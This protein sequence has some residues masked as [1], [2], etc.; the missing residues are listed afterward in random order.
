VNRSFWFL[1]TAA[2]ACSA[3]V[4][5]WCPGSALA[6]STTPEQV[7]ARLS[8]DDV[9]RAFGLSGVARE[10]TLPRL[11]VIRVGPHWYELAPELRLNA[12]AEWMELW[13]TSVASGVVAIVDAASE[14]SVVGFDAAG[15]PHLQNPSQEPAQEPAHGPAQGSTRGS[16]QS[17]DASHDEP[18]PLIMA[19]LEGDVA[20]ARA[21]IEDGA[22]PDVLAIVR[23]RDLLGPDPQ[24]D[25]ISRVEA[26]PL[27][28]AAAADA[29]ELVTLLVE[30]DAD[31][32]RTTEQGL[33]PLM[34]A[35]LD[36][37]HTAAAAL[38]DGGADPDALEPVWAEL[39]LAFGLAEPIGAEPG[40]EV[41]VTAL[42]AA[43]ALGREGL[44][45][46][47]LDHH[48]DPNLTV[49]GSLTPL[50]LA[51]RAGSLASV[52]ALVEANA[53]VDAAD[54]GG[55]TALFGAVSRGRRAVAEYLI[56][57]GADVAATTT[58]EET[59]LTAA[60]A[61]NDT[62]LARK[63][64]EAGADP[65]VRRADGSTLLHVATEHGYRPATTFLLDAGVPV[66]VATATGLTAL[67]VAARYDRDAVGAVL[68]ARGASVD[69]WADGSGTPLD[70]ALEWQSDRTA[71]LLRRAGARTRAQRAGRSAD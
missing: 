47:L 44:V 56:A 70:V 66:D 30:H 28:A 15:R 42:G 27:H 22:D 35:V 50:M 58:A 14:Q 18:E 63:L 67:H 31:V 54:D 29:A 37:S 68:L 10:P 49:N 21:L 64:I 38:L 53:D 25:P 46:V 45:A 19:A 23:S 12:A 1:A 71:E 52:R 59:P 20:R 39:L 4:V 9:A 36:G 34:V 16:A 26:T 60:I 57:H 69:A 3:A 24:S 32:D 17:A 6:H 61:R 2:L 55:T 43:A 40:T 65:E 41:D 7:V 5:V 48:A 8:A 13:R 11:L 33:T 51:A 62:D